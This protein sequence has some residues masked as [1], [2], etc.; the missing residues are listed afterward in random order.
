MLNPWLPDQLGSFKTVV[1]CQTAE[2]GG[3]DLLFHHRMET[4]TLIVLADLMGHGFQAKF[5]SH[6]LAGYLSGILAV[7]KSLSPEV[8]L[9]SLN[10]AFAEDAHFKKTIA[11]AVALL[12]SDDGHVQVSNA[13]Q[14]KPLFIGSQTAEHLPTSG[15]LLGLSLETVFQC[16]KFSINKGQRI[17]LY[18]DGLSEIGETPDTHEKNFSQIQ[19]VLEDATSLDISNASMKVEQCIDRMLTGKPRDDLT[20]VLIEYCG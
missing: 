20:F 6:A 5:Y 11:T 2:A 3:G 18:T 17:F 15:A 14:P 7:T 12:I 1:H 8:I 9:S 16:H 10:K 19:T 13:G 4:K